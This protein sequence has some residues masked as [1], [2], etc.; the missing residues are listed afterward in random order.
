VTD[1]GT[2]EPD[3]RSA[4]PEPPTPPSPLPPEAPGPAVLPAQAYRGVGPGTAVG[5][6]EAWLPRPYPQLLRGPGF[7]WWRPL[8]SFGVMFAGIGFVLVLAIA[9]SLLLYVVA[10]ATGR[11]ADANGPISENWEA[12]PGGMLFTNLVLAALIPAAML[13]VWAGFGW[14]P[15]WLG[16]VVG[17]LRRPWLA[18]CA[19]ATVMVVVLPAVLLTV[20]T[21]DVRAWTPEPNWPLLTAVVVLT[22]PLQA[23][24]EEYAFRGWLPQ[25]IGSMFVDARV[26]ALVGSGIASLLF[27]VAHGRQDPWLFADRF[28]FGLIACWL[29]W[30]TG[31]LEAAIAVHA[32]NNLAVFAFTIARGQLLDSITVTRAL[33]GEVIFDVATLVVVGAVITVLARRLR[34]VRLFVPPLAGVAW[35]QTS[36]RPQP[37]GPPGPMS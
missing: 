11:G 12:T 5:P 22:T 26:G 7:R 25:T 8:I 2:G 28:A 23:A 34:V 17:G 6:R 27:A 31:G 20:F 15:R 37:D 33:P 30:W 14:W 32:V 24:G 10:D 4:V 35:A 19:G 3:G 18:A 36:G 9:G 16:S 29:V 1:S 13:A 21:E